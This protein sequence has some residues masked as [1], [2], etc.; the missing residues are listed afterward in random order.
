MINHFLFRTIQSP[1]ATKF[2]RI[3]YGIILTLF[4]LS[5]HR[6][7][8]KQV[9]SYILSVYKIWG[10]QILSVEHFSASIQFLAMPNQLHYL[11]EYNLT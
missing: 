8:N 11:N 7:L 5:M 4:E 6:F 3:L 1:I 9:I 2:T 10:T